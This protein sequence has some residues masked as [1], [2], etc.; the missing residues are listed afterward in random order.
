MQFKLSAALLNV[1]FVFMASE[2]V[3]TPS[4]SNVNLYNGA[5]VV[6]VALESASVANNTLDRRD[7]FDCKGSSRCSNNQGF[8]SKPA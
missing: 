4:P 2:T 8:K 3:A 1:V 5:S 7:T 6:G